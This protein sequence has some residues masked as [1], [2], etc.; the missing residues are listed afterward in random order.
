MTKRIFHFE[1]LNRVANEGMTVL[2]D[3]L[4]AAGWLIE[5]GYAKAED[6]YEGPRITLT[7]AGQKLLEKK[8]R[9]N[10]QGRLKK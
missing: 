2:A 4:I 10:S 3:D 8:L 9:N 5:A 1:Y 6:D 7:K